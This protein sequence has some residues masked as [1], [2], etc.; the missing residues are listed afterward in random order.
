[1]SFFLN[2][3]LILSLIYN[4]ARV[5]NDPRNFFYKTYKENLISILWNYNHQPL[6]GLF[7]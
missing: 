1:M 4:F 2:I 7:F 3:E 6:E 5:L